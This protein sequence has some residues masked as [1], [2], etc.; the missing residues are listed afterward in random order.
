MSNL[1]YELS[2]IHHQKLKNEPIIHKI[3]QYLPLFCRLISLTDLTSRLG[4]LLQ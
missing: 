2:Y 1:N 4:S 3:I